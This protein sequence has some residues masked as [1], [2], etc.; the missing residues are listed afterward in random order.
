MFGIVIVHIYKSKGEST[1]SSK[2]SISRPRLHKV[3]KVPIEMAGIDLG[4]LEKMLL[5]EE[6]PDVT[7]EQIGGQ[8]KAVEE[9]RKLARLLKNPGIF[10]SW[11]VKPPRGILFY[12]EP[13]N[14]KTLLAKAL[15]HEAESVFMHVNASD[16]N[17]KWY[18]EAEKYAKGIFAIARKQTM[19]TGQHA[20]IFIDEVDSLMPS[21]S[22]G[23]GDVDSVT[24]RVIGEILKG[25]DGLES[26]QDITVIAA[27][28]TPEA[29]DKAFLSRMTKWVEVGNPDVEGIIEIFNIH[30]SI[31]SKKAGR[32]LMSTNI[33]FH[34][35]ANMHNGISGREIAD[36]VQVVL[37][38]KA[39]AHI[40]TG[41][42]TDITTQDIIN[43]IKSLGKS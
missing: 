5:I 39:N 25:I 28:N 27:T 18:G 1:P 10:E 24:R 4:E 41:I 33:D 35:I 6:I 16:I 14:G 13:G 36:V 12:G 37:S 15:A 17:S 20:I 42:I 38:D 21:R 23:A 3:W 9:A 30:F 26:S 40:E 7:F 22:G 11:G 8:K 34:S 32:Q 43:A 31:A 19:E 2:L 29:L